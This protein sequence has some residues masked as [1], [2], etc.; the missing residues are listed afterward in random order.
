MNRGPLNA[1]ETFSVLL[2]LTDGL[3]ST[4]ND[5]A[6]EPMA[7][8]LRNIGMQLDSLDRKTTNDAPQRK[9]MELIDVDMRRKYVAAFTKQFIK[10]ASDKGVPVVIDEDIPVNAQ[11]LIREQAETIEQLQKFGARMQDLMSQMKE[12]NAS[13]Q[14]FMD[15][16][17]D[18]RRSSLIRPLATAAPHPSTPS[19]THAIPDNILL[20]ESKQQ[21]Y[22]AQSRIAI[23]EKDLRLANREL[24]ELRLIRTEHEEAIATLEA[25]F[26]AL[27]EVHGSVKTAAAIEESR[28][29]FFA[30]MEMARLREQVKLLTDMAAQLREERISLQHGHIVEVGR[31]K[32]AHDQLVTMLERKIDRLQSEKLQLHEKSTGL[33]ASLRDMGFEQTQQLNRMVKNNIEMVEKQHRQAVC[34]IFMDA[35]KHPVSTEEKASAESRCS[36]QCTNHASIYSIASL[37]SKANDTARVARPPAVNERASGGGPRFGH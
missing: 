16:K 34:H 17:S 29:D 4:V 21:L 33:A 5:S 24:T 7:T 1:F 8:W 30:D 35:P 19:P 2:E 6:N 22:Q 32:S 3:M 36:R 27:N 11:A 23:L 10:V 18:R 9:K 20:I 14:N 31:I 26:H 28:R 13:R 12:V 25:A 15:R 37:P